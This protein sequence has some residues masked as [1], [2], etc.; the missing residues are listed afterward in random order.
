M[1]KLTNI[2]KTF[3]PGTIT[4]KKAI[5]GIDLEINDGDFITVIGSNGAGKS[6]LY[7]VIS[8]TYTPSEGKILL[9]KDGSL[10]KQAQLRHTAYRQNRLRGLSAERIPAALVRSPLGVEPVAQSQ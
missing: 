10:R 6:T 3:N 7:N 9:E 8:G 4:E 5:R 1:L 2:T